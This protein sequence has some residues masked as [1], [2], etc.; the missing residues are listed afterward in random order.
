MPVSTKRTTIYLEPELH[1][2]LRLK[3]MAVSQSLSE[4][5]NEAVRRSLTEDGEDLATFE[6][7]AG[8]PV[9]SYDEMLKRL[10]KHGRT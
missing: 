10:K 7:R 2:M 3:S 6:D 4:L 9:I 1:R 8:E 5:V